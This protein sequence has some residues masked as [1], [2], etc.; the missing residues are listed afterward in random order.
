MRK[1]DPLIQLEAIKAN[2]KDFNDLLDKTKGFKY[3]LQK[4]YLKKYKDTE[5]EFS[6]AY[7]NSTL[8]NVINHKFDPD[9]SFQEI[10]YRID[11]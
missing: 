10:L 3:L 5:T 2:I 8:K 4:S 1:K 6:R 7:F 9:Q 11:D